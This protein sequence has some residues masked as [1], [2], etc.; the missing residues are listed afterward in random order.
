ML[1]KV[2]YL[3]RN[4]NISVVPLYSSF[5]LAPVAGQLA[6]GKMAAVKWQRINGSGVIWQR[7]AEFA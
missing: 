3:K 4:Y 7:V 1:I 6:A 5:M 2:R